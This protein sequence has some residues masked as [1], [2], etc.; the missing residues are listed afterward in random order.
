MVACCGTGGTS[1]VSRGY[2]VAV[3][4]KRMRYRGAAMRKGLLAVVCHETWFDTE[5]CTFSIMSISPSTG[6]FSFVDQYAGHVP[7][8]H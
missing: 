2:Q 5:L 7:V 6:Q 8:S 4:E 1:E 3:C